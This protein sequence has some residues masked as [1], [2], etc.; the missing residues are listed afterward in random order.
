MRVVREYRLETGGEKR[1]C[2]RRRPTCKLHVAAWSPAFCPMDGRL[3][4]PQ[5]PAF[6]HSML[7]IVGLGETD[8]GRADRD[9]CRDDVRR[10]VGG[11]VSVGTYLHST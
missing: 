6:V 8:M 11:R 1:I 10:V 7:N 9:P 4:N 3:S 2:W 5:R